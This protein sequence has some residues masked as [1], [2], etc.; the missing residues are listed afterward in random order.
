MKYNIDIL[1]LANKDLYEINEYLSDFA[2]NTLMKF[3]ESFDKFIE[4]VSNM[5]YMFRECEHNSNYRMALLAFD[6]LIFYCIEEENN[7]VIISRI[8]HSKRNIEDLL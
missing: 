6:Y 1:R 3:N 7:T 4:Q 5:P 2:E 8:L